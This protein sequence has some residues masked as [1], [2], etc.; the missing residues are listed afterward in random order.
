MSDWNHARCKED[1][2]MYA[3]LSGSIALRPF[4]FNFLTWWCPDDVRYVFSSVHSVLLLLVKTTRMHKHNSADYT[5]RSSAMPSASAQL[6]WVQWRRKK[7]ESFGWSLEA[8]KLPQL[9]W[10]TSKVAK[11]LPTMQYCVHCWCASASAH[12]AQYLIINWSMNTSPCLPIATHL[13]AAIYVQYF[14]FSKFS[15]E[16]VSFCLKTIHILSKLDHVLCFHFL[17]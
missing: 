10:I 15:E 16:I 11:E 4:F 12:C 8:E 2:E 17:F 5:L 1:F 9:R 7:S 6:S 3:T 14:I 13:T